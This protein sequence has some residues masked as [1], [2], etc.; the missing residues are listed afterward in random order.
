MPSLEKL[1]RHCRLWTEEEDQT[2]RRLKDDGMHS[3]LIAERLG[4]SRASVDARLNEG[5]RP[6]RGVVSFAGERI[7]VPEQSLVD[8]DLRMEAL[9][10]QTLTQAFFGDPPP[11]YSMADKR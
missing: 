2:A 10:R 11:G 1:K 7:S 4:R 9:E 8:R 5:D 3:A 6:Q